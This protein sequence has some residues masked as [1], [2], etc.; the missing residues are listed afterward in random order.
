MGTLT[1]L[2]R[3]ALLSSWV[4][5]RVMAGFMSV[6]VTATTQCQNA[7]VT[8]SGDDGPWHLL[9]TPTNIVQHGYNLWVPEIPSN[10]TN[11]TIPINQPAGMQFMITMW[12]T[13]GIR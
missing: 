6:F 11:W 12:G 8:W 9:L 13:S 1:L 4:I 2:L 5:P 7:T 10:A 3:I